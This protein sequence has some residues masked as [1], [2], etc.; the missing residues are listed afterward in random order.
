MIAIT[1]LL[2]PF[3]CYTN[4]VNSKH[5]Q[6]WINESDRHNRAYGA[7]T[8]PS[9]K[10]YRSRIKN[11]LSLIF[12]HHIEPRA[13]TGHELK[14]FFL[15][16]SKIFFARVVAFSSRSAPQYWHTSSHRRT[17]CKSIGLKSS[18]LS[19]DE[20]SNLN[21]YMRVV[22]GNIFSRSLQDREVFSS[23]IL[24]I[25]ETKD[26][27][28]D[29]ARNFSVIVKRN[30]IHGTLASQIPVTLKL[31]QSA[32]THIPQGDIVKFLKEMAEVANYPYCFPHK[33]EIGQ[34]IKEEN[35]IAHIDQKELD[36]RYIRIYFRGA[37]L[38]KEEWKRRTFHLS[39]LEWY[40]ESDKMVLVDHTWLKHVKKMMPYILYKVENILD[41]TNT[42]PL[43]FFFIGHG[44]GGASLLFRR[45]I[46]TSRSESLNKI[47]FEICLVTFGAPRIG[48]LD[49]VKF[50]KRVM[51]NHRIY[52]VTH[53]N[54]DIPR[55]SMPKSKL[56]H[57]EKEYWIS[58]PNCDCDSQDIKDYDIY[59]CIQRTSQNKI[60]E[61]PGVDVLQI[62]IAADELELLELINYCQE[63]LIE[64]ES[65]WL[66]ENAVK[67][68]QTV[69]YHEAFGKLKEHYSRMVEDNP[70]FIFK[71]NDFL[72]LEESVLVFLLEIDDLDMKEIEVWKSL[73]KWGIGNTP[74]L[75]KKKLVSWG[76]EDFAAL[77]KTIHKCIPLIRYCDISG[78]DFF[79][80]VIPYKKVLPKSLKNEI[81][82][83]HLKTIPQPPTH[84]LPSRVRFAE[85]LIIK[86]RHVNIISSWIDK[87]TATLNYKSPY[88]FNLIYRGSRDGFTGRSFQNRCADYVNT[89]VVAKIAGSGK[90]VGGY[91]PTYWGDLV[92]RNQYYNRCG[93]Y[94]RDEY[95][96]GDEFYYNEAKIHFD[97]SEEYLSASD[98]FIFNLGDGKNS[99]LIKVAHSTSENQIAYNPNYG[100]YFYSDLFFGNSSN[101]KESC[102]YKPSSYKP[103]IFDNEFSFHLDEL[104]VFQVIKNI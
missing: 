52:R 30:D 9:Q 17:F 103:Q 7:G 3:N 98:A 28:I 70:D 63:H 15:M 51:S 80:H 56:L 88:T 72:S 73:I 100:P 89:V 12:A 1:I 74:R 24:E 39:S 50:S 78:D 95:Y 35:I 27:L 32:K 43:K 6:I 67:T 59:S 75:V 79:D 60:D 19:Q 31:V 81:W 64:K 16:G 8:R 102:W 57:L 54:D 14:N 58:K 42:L 66:Q 85:S 96:N 18:K 29:A 97:R 38:T 68:M 92:F 48:N 5:N 69:S 91:N 41:P 94:N 87:E 93:Y 33:N 40:E 26:N 101:E 86:S 13:C 53:S 47:A 10:P 25:K 61:H 76:A 49:F 22:L 104:E 37:H 77:E 46:L 99:N 21:R 82:A 44:I 83:Y 36:N 90:I 84:I 62:L 65:K 45:T 71:S 2:I 11:F 34:A 4:Q 23:G 55:D 20:W